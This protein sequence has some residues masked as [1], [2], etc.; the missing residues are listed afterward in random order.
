MS[1]FQPVLVIGSEAA[2]RDQ[3]MHMRM[4]GQI[5]CP[6]MQHSHHADLSTHKTWIISQLLGSL[7]RSLKENVVKE[8]LILPGQDSQLCRKGEGQEE[9]GYREQQFL[10]QLKPFLCPFLLA[11]GAVTIAAGMITVLNFATGRATVHLSTQGNRSAAL[12]VPHG[13][14]VRG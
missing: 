2:C 8:L 7:S 6:G 10:L 3:I 14:S 13:F 1:R 11:F 4:V 9:I 5:A 12:D